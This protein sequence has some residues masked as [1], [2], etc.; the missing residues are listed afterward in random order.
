M[1]DKIV[2]S[3]DELET[4]TS[5][6]A[7]DTAVETEHHHHHSGDDEHHHHSGGDEH[8][9]HSSDG[10]HHHHHHH[11]HSSSGS[12]KNDD[13]KKKKNKKESLAASWKKTV[14]QTKDY[15]E[16]KPFVKNLLIFLLAIIL[17]VAVI[18]VFGLIENKYFKNLKTQDGGDTVD[19]SAYSGDEV[20]IDGEIYVHK[21]NITSY[22]IIG[23]DKTGRFKDSKS[24]KN[25]QQCDFLA[26]IVFDSDAKTYKIVHINR[27][28]M[29]PVNVLG[30]NG[31]VAS[32][33]LMQIALSHTYGNGLER[34]VKNTTD[35]V[36]NLFYGM[37]V[38][39]YFAFTMS[40]VAE[41][42]DYVGG[43]P[44][45]INEDLT[46]ANPKF[47]E[48]SEI[49]L[50]GDDA[51]DFV[52]ARMSVS[53]GTNIKRME[54]QKQ[55]ISSL[56]ELFN[57]ADDAEEF[58]LGCMHSMQKYTLTNIESKDIT[59]LIDSFDEYEFDGLVSPEGEATV[60]RDHVRFD[61]DEDSFKDFVLDLFFDKK[62]E[63]N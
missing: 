59:N 29:T 54:R 24:Y 5:A 28:T 10:E 49:S 61:I 40:G 63:I 51:L 53:D 33:K 30:V 21:K 60:E 25:E 13:S 48:G 44:V 7:T 18:L 58:V 20:Y 35:A 39:K 23:V 37:N 47:T 9:H 57:D 43:V 8:H 14:K 22:L 34:S 56:M 45:T 2:Q 62:E 4:V 55:F 36:S 15:L 19:Y 16:R 11:H 3:G 50:K 52:R 42:A 41:I 32:T 31:Q 27:D 26:L 6:P 1:D 17:C 46:A 12:S 38:D